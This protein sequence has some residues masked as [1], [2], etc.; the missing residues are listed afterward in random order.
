MPWEVH[1]FVEQNLN[2]CPPN[3]VFQSAIKRSVDSL[4]GS[5]E[6]PTIEKSW[7]RTQT[8]R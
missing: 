6:Q 1:N 8:Y 3:Y 4:Y 5:R 7:I 2:L